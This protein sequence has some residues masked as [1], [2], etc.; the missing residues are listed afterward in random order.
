MYLH[1]ESTW[2]RSG[3]QPLVA[4]IP[5]VPLAIKTFHTL[6][7]LK[8]IALFTVLQTISILSFYFKFHFEGFFLVSTGCLYLHSDS[9]AGLHENRCNKNSINDEGR[10]K[11]LIFSQPVQKMCTM[12]FFQT[13]GLLFCQ[14]YR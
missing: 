6:M 8:W 1:D 12:R 3:I 2:L 9:F 10:Y 14:R 7:P 5:F 11:E 4:F 13:I